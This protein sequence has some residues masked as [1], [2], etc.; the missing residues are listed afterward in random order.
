M[1]RWAGIEKMDPNYPVKR[2]LGPYRFEIP[3]GYMTGRPTPEQVNCYPVRKRIEF[4]FWMPDLRAPKDDTWG[5][6]DFRPQEPGRDAPGPQDYIVEVPGV[7]FID[8]KAGKSESPS[9]RFWN[10]LSMLDEA[11]GFEQKY[12]LLRVLPG[13]NPNVYDDY[14]DL[15]QE[16][17]KIILNCS[18]PEDH[19]LNPLCQAYLYFTDLQL[20]TVVRFPADAL[21]EWRKIKD[22]V[23]TLAERWIVK[24]KPDQN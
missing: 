21:P 3:F 12:G 2:I 19:R 10:S 23:R 5:K 17:Y 14:S 22:G 7:M 1:D 18:R 11:F 24:G 15:S 6:S 4:A 13:K 20:E 8:T 9:V 16:D